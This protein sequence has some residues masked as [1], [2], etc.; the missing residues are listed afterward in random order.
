MKKVIIFLV[1]IA[2]VIAGIYY[3]YINYRAEYN[4]S[5]KANKAFEQYLN[6]EV[7]GPDLATII[8][9]AMNENEKNKV[10]KDNKGIYL[11]NNTNSINI[12]VKMSDDNQIYKAETFYNSGIQNF[13]NYYRNIKFKCVDIKYHESTH[14]VKYMLFE[15]LTE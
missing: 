14:K 3:V 5:I 13:I 1:I 6:E 15:Q 7:Y 12:E 8:N 2:V 9:R 4:S 11:D 10:Q